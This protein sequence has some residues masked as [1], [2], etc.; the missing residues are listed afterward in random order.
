MK[1]TKK[2]EIEQVEEYLRKEG[3]TEITKKEEESPEFKT[4]LLKIHELKR[5]CA[6]RKKCDNTDRSILSKKSVIKK[7]AKH[8]G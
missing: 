1:K 8:L 2:T 4:S 7:P 5:R 6:A 3:F